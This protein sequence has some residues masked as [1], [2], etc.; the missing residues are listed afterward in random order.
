G[1]I[2]AGGQPQH[3]DEQH[4]SPQSKCA[5]Y[6]HTILMFSIV[7]STRPPARGG[8]R[9][10]LSCATVSPVQ[11]PCHLQSLRDAQAAGP[12]WCPIAA[13]V[14]PCHGAAGVPGEPADPWMLS[15]G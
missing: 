15:D 9:L 12:M 8:W 13:R 3:S 7:S 2:G 10:P 14:T 1:V 6:V 4:G 5:M 11:I